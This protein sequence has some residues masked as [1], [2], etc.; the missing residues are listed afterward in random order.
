[1][2]ENKASKLFLYLTLFFAAWYVFLCAH[3]FLNQRALWNDE[4]AVFRSVGSFAAKDFFTRPLLSVQ[5][6]PRVY[7][8]L[9]QKISQSFNF[10]LLALRFLPFLCMISAFYLWLKRAHYELTSPREY[11]FFVM[12]WPASALLIYYSAELKQY[13]MDVLVGVL[14]LIFLYH[15]K[16]L[17]QKHERLC[18]MISLALPAL[19]M[20][21]YVTMF[22]ILWPLYN[23]ALLYRQNP[24]Y[25]KFLLVYAASLA[26]FVSLSYFFDMRWRPLETVTQAWGD[27]FI[28]FQS[29]AEFFKTLGEGTV[30]L[31]TRWF[32]EQPKLIK[33]IASFFAAFGF[34]NMFYSFLKSFKKEG[35]FLRSLDVV[36][37]IIFLE[38]IVLGALKK[39]PFTVPRTSLFFCPFVLYLTVQAFENITQWNKYIGWAL[40]G[41]YAIFLTVMTY[42]LARLILGGDLG[43]MPKLW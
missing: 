35:Y 13:S 15:Q 25:L 16:S 18:L 30:N 37:L 3:H 6:F 28:S 20:F 27:Y 9:I 14:F 43:A 42:S 1:M 19:M 17:T 36:P 24:R 23:F 39:Y 5:V 29:P 10:H 7:L 12:S 31:F 11:L 34:I 2:P 33:K 21:S 22:F 8:F 26:A 38:L 32:A 41:L 4:E 40:F